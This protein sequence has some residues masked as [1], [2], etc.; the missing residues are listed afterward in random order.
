MWDSNSRPIT[1]TGVPNGIWS[2]SG[3]NNGT[4]KWTISRGQRMVQSAMQDLFGVQM[5][6]G[7]VNR[8]R[9]EAS[10]AVADSVAATQEYVQQQPVV[11]ADETSF[12]LR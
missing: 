1:R 3:G 4:A 7:T 8:L 2:E 5:C 11:G 12:A 9:Q 10:A 6:L